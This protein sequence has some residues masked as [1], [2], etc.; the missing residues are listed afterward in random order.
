M[1][2]YNFG[3]SDRSGTDTAIHF[4]QYLSDRYPDKVVLSIDGIGAFDHVSRTRMFE[5]LLARPDLHDLIP[6]VK[7]WYGTAS[8]FRWMDDQGVCHTI[9]QGDGGE[10]GDA[11]M[12]A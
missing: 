1:W 7:M 6:F 4:L 11:L 8:E 3:L 10:Q 2:P 9:V 5:H 12:L